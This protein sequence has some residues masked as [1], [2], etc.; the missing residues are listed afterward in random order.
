MDID[1]IKQKFAEA[2]KLN[3]CWEKLPERH[4]F[5]ELESSGED[6]REKEEEIETTFRETF[7]FFDELCRVYLDTTMEQCAAIRMAASNTGNITILLQKYACRSAKQIQNYSDEEL[8]LKGL[9]AAS[10]ENCSCD[11]RDTYAMLRRLSK[12]ARKV[13]IN[14]EPHFKTVAKRSSDKRSSGGCSEAISEMLLS[15]HES[16]FRRSVG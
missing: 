1:E 3:N 6:L 4:L 9:A 7:Q 10:I 16:I 11:Y 2:D 15:Y 8:L 12:A 5:P 14:P 13:G